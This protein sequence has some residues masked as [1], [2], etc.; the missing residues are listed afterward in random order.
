MG[1]SDKRVQL[2]FLGLSLQ[3][4]V[5]VAGAVPARTPLWCLFLMSRTAISFPAEAELPVAI[6]QPSPPARL[7]SQKSEP[8]S[9]ASPA[10][11][12]APETKAVSKCYVQVTGMTCASCVANIERNLRREDGKRDVSVIWYI[13]ECFSWRSRLA[14]VGCF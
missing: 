13:S 1:E 3:Q 11:L 2:P 7:E 4:R 12:T 5:F 14:V 6:A 10:H 8:P 9:K